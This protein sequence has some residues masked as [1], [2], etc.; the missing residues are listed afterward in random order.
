MNTVLS[1]ATDETSNPNTKK[2][3]NSKAIQFLF[4]DT[5]PLLLFP[6]AFANDDTTGHTSD[7]PS[8][9]HGG[10]TTEGLRLLA[11]F[12]AGSIPCCRIAVGVIAIAG[13]FVDGGFALT[14]FVFGCIT[15]CRVGA[16]ERHAR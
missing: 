16:A 3:R 7:P 8:T 11:R 1:E 5:R 2:T 10:E 9:P 14:R 6:P 15:V 4:P 12:V 13:V